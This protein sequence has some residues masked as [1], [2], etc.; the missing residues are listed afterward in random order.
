VTKHN[1]FLTLSMVKNKIVLFFLQILTKISIW[2]LHKIIHVLYLSGQFFSRKFGNRNSFRK[3]WLLNILSLSLIVVFDKESKD[4]WLK[5]SNFGLCESSLKI[6]LSES[7][8]KLKVCLNL[9]WDRKFV[10]ILAK[11]YISNF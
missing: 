8:L 5:A 2:K 10:C 6:I 3:K 9:T 11:S 1:L 4:V 7:G